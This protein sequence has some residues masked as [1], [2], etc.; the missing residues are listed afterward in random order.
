MG[1]VFLGEKN[2][3]KA[4]IKVVRSS[5][6]DDP[7]LKS[8]IIREIEVLKKIR[9]PNIAE[10]IETDIEASSAWFA[11][12]FVDGP[13]L[14]VLVDNNGPL[15]ENSWIN[16]T[17]ELFNG[18]ESIHN[19]NIIHR[20]VKPS[21]ILIG[22]DKPKIIDFGI[23]LTDEATSLTTTGLVAGSPAWLSPEQ[24]SGEDL[25][26]KSDI[27]SLGSVLVFAAVGSSPWS[28]EENTRTPT[29]FNRILSE[30]PRLE[31]LTVF[32]KKL[33]SKLLEKDPKNRL[34]AKEAKKLV[35]SEIE[36]RTAASVLAQK[37]ENDKAI[38]LADKHKANN[39]L[40]LQKI[41]KAN[42]KVKINKSIDNTQTE[43]IQI[44]SRIIFK[45]S[46][47]K[48][49]L[50]ASVAASGFLFASIY[51][52]DRLTEQA[53]NGTVSQ[54]LI[55][56][57][58]QTP[59]AEISSTLPTPD[60]T[61]SAIPEASADAG[62]TPT[63]EPTPTDREEKSPEA[64]PVAD[65]NKT[66]NSTDSK[67]KNARTYNQICRSIDI[68]PGKNICWK[69]QSFNSPQWD[70]Q[71]EEPPADQFNDAPERQAY[72]D[73]VSQSRYDYKSKYPIC[74]RLSGTY[75]GT[76]TYMKSGTVVARDNN[77]WEFTVGTIAHFHNGAGQLGRGIRWPNLPFYTY[78][79]CITPNG[80]PGE[81]IEILK[82]EGFTPYYYTLAA[83]YR[84][85]N[86][87][88]TIVTII[89]G[90]GF[91]YTITDVFK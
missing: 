10:I 87:I 82:L 36:K 63:E 68:E 37:I 7:S 57:T 86:E 15:D 40:R 34:S 21:N 80:L 73:W 47:K 24:I 14:K 77:V 90:N 62:P 5:F 31:G 49:I 85:I 53:E 33:V 25:S 23:A 83:G 17:S 22:K 43:I 66:E 9:G 35:K 69:K 52:M 18:F 42:N 44:P 4:A 79:N 26:T 61:Q 46:F 13:N 50:I 78:G 19:L 88:D 70:P 64:M 56:E 54:A 74:L 71:W 20:D 75:R 76:T 65:G 3:E 81:L 72:L 1:V 29:F 16:L 11:T 6:L 45:K 48:P 58:V 51:F 41:Q 84:P 89:N 59:P 38:K 60:I 2:S 39:Q 8:R 32:Q 27:F 67:S 55:S 30:N 28:Q 91:A 12:E